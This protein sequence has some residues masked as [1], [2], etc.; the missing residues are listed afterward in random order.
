[1]V[2]NNFVFHKNLSGSVEKTN[3][4]PFLAGK[5][6]KLTKGKTD[7]INKVKKIFFPFH[8]S[9][10]FREKFRVA[11]KTRYLFYFSTKTIIFF[12]DFKPAKTR[13]TFSGVP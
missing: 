1:M 11:S 8:R 2:T 12:S 13:L 4:K 5:L 7:E 10:L 6:I 3:K 9:Q